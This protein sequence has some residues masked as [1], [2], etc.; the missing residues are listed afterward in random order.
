MDHDSMFFFCSSA[1]VAIKL[2]ALR[3]ST[4]QYKTNRLCQLGC[5]E[6]FFPD[7]QLL[8]RVTF[9]CLLDSSIPHRIAN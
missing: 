2:L 9:L 5:S 8:G 6:W 7:Q 1:G 3:H 4:Q